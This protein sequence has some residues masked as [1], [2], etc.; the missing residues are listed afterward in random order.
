MILRHTTDNMQRRI[1]MRLVIDHFHY[2]TLC[3]FA[4]ESYKYNHIIFSHVFGLQ[5]NILVSLHMNYPALMRQ[6]LSWTEEPR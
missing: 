6:T 2:I 5:L 1:Q 3:H 4:R